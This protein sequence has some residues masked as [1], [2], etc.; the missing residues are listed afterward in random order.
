MMRDGTQGV[1][2]FDEETPSDTSDSDSLLSASREPEAL[3]RPTYVYGSR[4]LVR[5]ETISAH[6]VTP[7]RRSES[8]QQ[9]PTQ[10]SR[11]E[12]N[13]NVNLPL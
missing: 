9:R 1:L 5:R 6:P 10:V 8:F 3:P 2:F 13:F 11:V 7:I 12:L 4:P